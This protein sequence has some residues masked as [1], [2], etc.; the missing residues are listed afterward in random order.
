MGYVPP[1]KPLDFA[2]AT[3][4]LYTIAQIADV[5]NQLLAQSNARGWRAWLIDGYERYRY[6]LYGPRAADRLPAMGWGFTISA[7]AGI[8]TIVGR[9][10]GLW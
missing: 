5:G 3:A 1:S 2:R 10:M 7:I 4:T 6:D 8:V 9:I